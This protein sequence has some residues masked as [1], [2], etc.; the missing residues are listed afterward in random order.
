MAGFNQALY[1]AQACQSK[2]AWENYQSRNGQTFGQVFGAIK[3]EGGFDN[4]YRVLVEER[5]RLGTRAALKVGCSAAIKDIEDGSW[6]IYKGIRFKA[7]YQL[8][9]GR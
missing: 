2:G 5:A 4:K 6:D 9:M 1:V 3:A 8:F 7:D